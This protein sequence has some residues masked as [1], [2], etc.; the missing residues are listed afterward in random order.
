MYP[1]PSE[2]SVDKLDLRA[3]KDGQ[4]LTSLQ[5]QKRKKWIDM[6]EEN[7]PLKQLICVCLHD[8]PEKR[9]DMKE[10][11]DVLEDMLSKRGGSK[12]I[13]QLMDLMMENEDKKRELVQLKEEWRKDKSDKETKLIELKQECEVLIDERESLLN[14]LNGSHEQNAI[15]TANEEELLTNNEALMKENL[16]MIDLLKTYIPRKDDSIAAIEKAKE[17]RDKHLC[18]VNKIISIAKFHYSIL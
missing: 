13:P 1:F 7:H 17:E 6:L 4:L 14:D 18:K 8:F 15:L 16:A 2:L 9:Y 10:A 3:N 12:C 5:I 11:R